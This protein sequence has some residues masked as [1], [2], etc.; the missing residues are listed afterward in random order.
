VWYFHFAISNNH[1]DTHWTTV[2]TACNTVRGL[3]AAII[4]AVLPPI[5][6]W[7]AACTDWHTIVNLPHAS[8]FLPSFASAA[9]PVYLPDVAEGVKTRG[10]AAVLLE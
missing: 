4:T 6:H 10:A 8:L 3:P 2:L 9:P 7:A 5:L 1:A